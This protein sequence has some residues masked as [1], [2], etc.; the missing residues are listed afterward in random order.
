MA[1]PTRLCHIKGEIDM[2][3]TTLAALA[4]LAIA[5]APAFAG[6]CP[7]DA[8]AIDHA[9]PLSTLSNDEKAEIQALRDQGMAA[10]EAGDHATSEALLAN[11]MRRLLLGQGEG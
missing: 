7:A 1:R 4:L 3:R 9:L 6:H 5:A 8:A 10:H 2:I 11:A